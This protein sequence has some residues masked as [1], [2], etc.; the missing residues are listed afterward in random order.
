MPAVIWFWMQVN[1]TVS[2]SNVTKPTAPSRTRTNVSAEPQPVSRMACQRA[3]GIT[4]DSEKPY[5]DIVAPPD[6]VRLWVG[7]AEVNALARG[8][9]TNG[10]LAEADASTVTRRPGKIPTPEKVTGSVVFVT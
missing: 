5:N 2:V 3:A 7:D 9:A 4:V 1:P 8:M 6:S 10:P